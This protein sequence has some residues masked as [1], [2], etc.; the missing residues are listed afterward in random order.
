[1]ALNEE[2]VCTSMQGNILTVSTNKMSLPP[3]IYTQILGHPNSLELP[4]QSTWFLVGE[5]VLF[6]GGP[7][8]NLCQCS[9][10]TKGL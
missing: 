9:I 1:M 5:G 6:S 10:C 4:S 2:Y 8:R 7:G 3:H